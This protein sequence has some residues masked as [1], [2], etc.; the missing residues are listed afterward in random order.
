MKKST[1]LTV[2]L[3][4]VDAMREGLAF[5]EDFIYF[6]ELLKQEQDLQK[7]FMQMQNYLLAKAVK[8][9]VN[10]LDRLKK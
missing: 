1:G 9:D 6:G 7:V 5:R 4:L 2:F 8:H 3:T 10:H